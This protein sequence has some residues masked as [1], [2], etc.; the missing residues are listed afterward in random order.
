[1]SVKPCIFVVK[2]GTTDF[3]SESI[4]GHA[5]LQPVLGLGGDFFLKGASFWE[6]SEPP[7]LSNLFLEAFSKLLLFFECIIPI[8]SM[9]DIFAYIWL[10]FMVNVLLGIC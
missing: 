1:M 3:S 10:I 8:G 2:G 9:Y 7:K 5:L 6:D 4:M